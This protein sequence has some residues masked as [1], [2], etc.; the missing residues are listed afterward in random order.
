MTKPDVN[1]VAAITTEAA[2]DDRSSVLTPHERKFHALKSRVEKRNFRLGVTNGV[3]YGLGTYFVSRSTVIPSFLSHLTSSSALI[4]IVSQF[5]SI[6]WYLPQFFVASFVVHMPRKMPLY[7]IGW[8]VRG[9]AL[10]ALAIL[11]LMTSSLHVLLIGSLL[12]YASFAA[13]A[14]L[15]GVVFLEVVAKA[16]PSHRRGRFFGLRIT[17][18]SVLSITLG[19]ATISLLLGHYAFPTN[20]GYVFLC[21]AIIVTIGLGFLAIMREPREAK[22]PEPRTLREHFREG[23]QIYRTDKAYAKYIHTRLIMGSWTIGVPFLVLFASEKLA[24]KTVDLG[25]FIA[26]DCIGTVAG[27]FWWEHLTDKRSAKKCLQM[28]TLV[29]ALLPIVVLLYLFLPLPRIGYAVVFALAAAVDAGVTIGG[30]TYLIEISPG[31]DRTTY[32]GLFNSLMALP[33]ILSAAA[34]VLLDF[35]GFGALYGL[36][37]A[38]SIISIFAVLRL[39]THRRH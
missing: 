36:V 27:N 25:I 20:F 31:H 2:T 28:A 39:E 14:G 7:R 38:I 34:G 6:G 12:L 15:S 37:L 13:G 29:S 5:E 9:A 21:G 23:W 18:A 8:W 24:F 4:G 33:L 26:A 10:F 32:I 19:A 11:T 16:I 30:M 35:A 3:L 1:N 22:V 17:Y